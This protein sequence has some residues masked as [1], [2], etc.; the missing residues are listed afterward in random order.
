MK[1]NKDINKEKQRTKWGTFET[2]NRI[3]RKT[4]MRKE[5]KE[6]ATLWRT[7]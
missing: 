5:L 7:I 6:N 2:R 1:G 3:M 4:W